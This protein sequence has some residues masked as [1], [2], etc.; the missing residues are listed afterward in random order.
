M[1]GPIVLTFWYAEILRTHTWK[2]G[3]AGQAT[4]AWS[5]MQQKKNRWPG[6]AAA[7]A[8]GISGGQEGDARW[9]TARTDTTTGAWYN[10]DGWCDGWTGRRLDFYSKRPKS[11]FQL[12]SVLEYRQYIL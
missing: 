7:E 1:S 9:E 3:A 5:K 6:R 11:L 2:V 8:L 10:A 4:M 12:F